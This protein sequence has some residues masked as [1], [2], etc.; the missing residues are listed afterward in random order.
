MINKFTL[1]TDT[2]SKEEFNAVNKVMISRNYTMGDMVEK[3]EK[4]LAKWI[5][6][7]NVYLKT[8]DSE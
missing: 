2:F 4:N 8:F 1:A 6:V 5:G 7:K 3:F